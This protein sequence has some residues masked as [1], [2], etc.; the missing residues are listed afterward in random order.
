MTNQMK[1]KHVLFKSRYITREYTPL[2]IHRS[3]SAAPNKQF[4]PRSLTN[5]IL[6][7]KGKSESDYTNASQEHCGSSS[8]KTKNVLA[9]P[10]NNKKKRTIPLPSVGSFTPVSHM[11]ATS[12][13]AINHCKQKCPRSS[14]SQ[15]QS[16]LRHWLSFARFT[17]TLQRRA[18]TTLVTAHGNQQQ[19]HPNP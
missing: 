17:Q 3:D 6:Q 18:N 7:W 13:L 15:E 5:R 16:C 12:T 1:S 4:K 8:L 9:H 11:W 10:A 19:I 2:R 14:T